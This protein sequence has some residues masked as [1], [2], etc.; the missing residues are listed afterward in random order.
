MIINRVHLFYFSPTGTTIKVL[1]G[2]AEGIGAKHNTFTD[3][4]QEDIKKIDLDKNETDMVVI[5]MPTYASRVPPEGELL[6]QSLKGDGIPIILVAVYGNNR[7]GDALLEMKN[8]TKSNGFIP[9]AAGA[10]IGEHSFSTINKPIA[11]NRPDDLDIKCAKKFGQAVKDKFSKLDKI[12]KDYELELPGNYP[13]KE[14]N[15]LSIAPPETDE[16]LCVKCKKCESTCPV[17][18][19]IVAQKVI[20][21]SK[22]CI[23]CSSCIKECPTNARRFTDL[24]LIEITERLHNNCSERKE[25]ELFF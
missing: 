6:M 20:T 8:C 24:K 1:K 13:Y 4:T 22:L 25:P 2:I 17:N 18:A 7:F 21:D 14:W 12:S 19:I 11:P 23:F 10:F 9:T 5:G 15:K 16:N 3:L